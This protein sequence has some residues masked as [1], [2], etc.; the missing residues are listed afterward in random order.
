MILIV[1]PISEMERMIRDGMLSCETSLEFCHG[2][3]QQVLHHIEVD[4]PGLLIAPLMLDDINAADLQLS[5]MQKTGSPFPSIFILDPKFSEIKTR[6]EKM[7]TFDF[8]PPDYK[9]ADLLSRVSKIPQQRGPRAEGRI[10][11]FLTPPKKPA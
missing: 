10:E 11:S 8:L 7:G 9:M 1:N 3:K 4:R 2:L 5:I 6:L